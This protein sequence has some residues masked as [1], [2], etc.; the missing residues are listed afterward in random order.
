MS[1]TQFGAPSFA[2]VALGIDPVDL[3]QFNFC[4]EYLVFRPVPIKIG[5]SQQGGRF[6]AQI[7]EKF[8]DLVLTGEDFIG[9]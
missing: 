6:A 7:R 3:P 2:A 9:L 8:L 1:E 4:E 5:C